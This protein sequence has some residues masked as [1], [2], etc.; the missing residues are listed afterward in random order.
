M[1]ENLLII[2]YNQKGLG[3]FAHC[4]SKY[5]KKYNIVVATN[6]SDFLNILKKKYS[7]L[8]TLLIDD[9]VTIF[10]VSNEVSEIRKK[11]N[12]ALKNYIDKRQLLHYMKHVEGGYTSARIQELV[13]IKKLIM[14]IFQNNSFHK[15]IEIYDNRYR[16]DS[17]V[18]KVYLLRNKIKYSRVHATLFLDMLGNFFSFVRPMLYEPYRLVNFVRFNIFY[19][20]RVPVQENNIIAFSLNSDAHKFLELYSSFFSKLNNQGVGYIFVSNGVLKDSERIK[21]IKDKIY[22]QEHYENIFDYFKSLTM[23]CLFTF[24]FIKNKKVIIEKLHVGNEIIAHQLYLSIFYHIVIDAGFRYR[25]KKSFNAFLDENHDKILAFKLW[26]EVSLHQGEIEQKIIK[27]NYPDIKTIGFEVGIGLKTFPYVP[28]KIKEIDFI[29]TSNNM[30]SDLYLSYGVKKERLLQLINFKNQGYLSD[31]KR[32]YTSSESMRFLKISQDQY[33]S[34]ILVD[35][36]VSMRGYLSNANIDHLINKINA[37]SQKFT[38][39]L[40]LIKP[41]PGFKDTDYLNGQFKNSPNITVFDKNLSITHL[42]NIADVLITKYS[43]A[44]IEAIM[45]GKLVI[46]VLSGSEKKFAAFENAAIYINNYNDLDDIL[47]NLKFYKEK[48]EPGIFQFKNGI[49]NI[50]NSIGMDVVISRIKRANCD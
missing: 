43:A 46:S 48:I 11:I 20:K 10:D 38:K 24:R 30:E 5:E 42:I 13:I 17:I 18:L 9:S 50:D 25:Y 12:R 8:T 45:L 16:L 44:G 34:Y 2:V 47:T 39:Y 28:K 15:V 6:N 26:G 19:K 35:V 7:K 23:V 14:T 49:L 29:V 22:L 41:H 3:K 1:K 40:F 4:Y 31:F 21:S 33:E 27:E 37:L 32:R 36:G